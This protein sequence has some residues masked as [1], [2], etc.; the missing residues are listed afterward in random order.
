MNDEPIFPPR[1]LL[2]WIGA[3]VATLPALNEVLTVTVYP[4]T[5]MLPP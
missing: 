1:V 5:V 4:L 2:G 3:A